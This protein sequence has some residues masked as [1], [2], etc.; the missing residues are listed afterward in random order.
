M[1]RA[2]KDYLKSFKVSGFKW[3][4][5]PVSLYKS[6]ED[7]TGNIEISKKD[8]KKI[9]DVAILRDCISKRIIEDLKRQIGY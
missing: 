5:D 9:F 8:L 1:K 2:K 4:I 3:D 6:C 7:E